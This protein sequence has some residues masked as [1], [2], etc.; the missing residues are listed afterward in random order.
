MIQTGG[1][2]VLLLCKK[3]LALLPEGVMKTSVWHTEDGTEK[4]Q[5]LGQELG[6]I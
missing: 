2:V 6:V 4:K 5:S 1:L 3:P